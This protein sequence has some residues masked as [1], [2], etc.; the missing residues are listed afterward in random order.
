MGEFTQEP[1]GGVPAQAFVG[2]RPAI[3]ELVERSRLLV[4]AF[5][6]AFHHDAG[7]AFLTLRDAACDIAHDL[8]LTML[9]LAGIAV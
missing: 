9:V 1:L 6:E 8:G 4:A 7:D 2:D 3:Y 5:D